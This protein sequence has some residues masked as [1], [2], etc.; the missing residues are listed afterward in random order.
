MKSTSSAKSAPLVAPKVP[1][2]SAEKSIPRTVSN[3][4]MTSGQ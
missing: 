1:N 3:V 2:A 4:T